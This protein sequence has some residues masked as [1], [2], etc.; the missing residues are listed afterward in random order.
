MWKRD[1]TVE[2]R[3]GMMTSTLKILIN[4]LNIFIMKCYVKHITTLLE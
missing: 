1:I 3:K 4:Y 2:V